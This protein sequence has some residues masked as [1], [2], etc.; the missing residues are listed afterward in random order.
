MLYNS[1]PIT[2][3]QFQTGFISTEYKAQQINVSVKYG[4]LEPALMYRRICWLFF[5]FDHLV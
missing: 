4:M 5:V 3:L 2:K 1:C